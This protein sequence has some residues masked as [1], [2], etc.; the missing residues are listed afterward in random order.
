VIRYVEA[1]AGHVKAGHPEA[2]T[3]CCI[4]PEDQA[5]WPEVAA[6]G[7]LDNVGTDVYWANTG[8]DIR[9][10]EPVAGE[11][12]HLCRAAG[13]RQHQWLQC[14]GVR[15]GNEPRIAELGKVLCAARPHG[16]YVW[17]FEGQVG[18]NEACDDPPRAWA[19]ACAV[20][21]LAKGR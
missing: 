19:A 20:L 4:P 13:K 2:E 18:T 21:R 5:L 1:V 6:L 16:L 9:A 14:W 17:A 10:A 15:A 12:A 11:L 7:P 8:Q 3:F